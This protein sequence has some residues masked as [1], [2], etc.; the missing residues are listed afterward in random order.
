MFTQSIWKDTA[1]IHNHQVLNRDISAD[2]A[3]IGGGV[4]GI[5]TARLLA[6]QGLKVVVAESLKVGGGTSGHST[7]NLYVT[8]D[9]NLETLKN[10]YDLE[11][12]KQV[13]QSRKDALNLIESWVKAYSLDCDFKRQNW[14]LYSA[15]AEND[16]KIEQELGVAR[17]AGLEI[18]DSDPAN[19]PLKINKG[20]TLPNQAQLNPMRYVQELANVADDN[21]AIYE[22]TRVI[23]IEESDEGVVLHTS[24]GNIHAD[25]AVMA[26]H[27]PKGF[28]LLQTL[29]GSYREY[30]V[31]FKA[32]DLDFPE[33]IF[34]GYHE[35]GKNISSRLYERNGERYVIFV[36]EPHK[37]GQTEDNIQHIQALCDFAQT[38]YGLNQVVY[39]WGGQHYRPADLLPFIG[40]RNQNG[41]TFVATGFSTDGLVYGTLAAMMIADEITGR[42]N[43]YSDLYNPRR[44][45]PIKSASRFIAENV[46]V[47]TVFLKDLP[48]GADKDSFADIKVGEGAVINYQGEKIAAYRRE[49]NELHLNSAVC[50]HLKCIVN[51][52]NAEKTWDC[53]CHGSRFSRD[54]V[55]LEGPSWDNLAR[56]KF[57]DSLPDDIQDRK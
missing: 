30:G 52:N 53:P 16:E 28:D 13:L 26:T 49:D 17:E 56:A 35:D 50:P 38:H 31:A 25:Y 29:L 36:G 46:N 45:T 20:I 37:T 47:A 54:G 5:S 41:R 27:V 4:T 57:K 3:I 24:G 39:R 34:W 14:N 19:Y 22:C 43:P 48:S 33:G 11:T 40:R 6:R 21:I 51:W 42:S 23:K 1:S 9:K 15:I 7:G 32:G 2:V 12:V 10:K 44:F 18:I 55:V 8:I